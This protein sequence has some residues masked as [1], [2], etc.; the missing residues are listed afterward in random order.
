MLNGLRRA[1]SV[2]KAEIDR[3]EKEWQEA[4]HK[5]GRPKKAKKVESAIAVDDD[6]T[7]EGAGASE[8]MRRQAENRG[9][10]WPPTKD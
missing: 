4:T 8:Y 3:R 10:K 9:L 2:P 1:L 7:I 5:R 6:R